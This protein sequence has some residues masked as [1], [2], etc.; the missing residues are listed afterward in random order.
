MR[1]ALVVVL[2]GLLL[3]GGASAAPSSTGRVE[4]EVLRNG[5]PFGRHSVVVSESA[6]RITARSAVDLRVAA[7]P[8]TLFRYEHDC[9][10]T[11]REGALAALECATLKEGR[12]L[13]VRATQAGDQLI[14]NGTAG[15]IQLPADVRP[16]SW[17]I[18]PPA[19]ADFMLDTETG[20]RLP[21][22]ISRL[23]RET[24]AVGGQRIAADRIRVEG[25]VVVDL[26]YDEGGRWVGCA[27]NVRGQRIEY[28]LASPLSGAPT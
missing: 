23:G 5:Q 6:G 9:V 17:W 12:R 11:W 16:T 21:L 26:W 4:F 19:D 20:A 8:V 24:I 10:E 25:T 3:G 1:C 22:R 15:D 7:G 2:A 14:V 27:F 28:R 18:R 13:S